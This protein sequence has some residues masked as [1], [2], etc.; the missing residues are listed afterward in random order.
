[1]KFSTTDASEENTFAFA[2]I[3]VDGDLCITDG[4]TYTCISPDG[5]VHP[6][7]DGTDFWP[8]LENAQKVF[9]VGDTLTITF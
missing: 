1:M 6:E 4:V 8:P 9:R 2:M 5:T 3:D 7:Y